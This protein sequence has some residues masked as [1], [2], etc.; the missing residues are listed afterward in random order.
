LADRTLVGVPDQQGTWS[1]ARLARETFALTFRGSRQ[2]LAEV[3]ARRTQVTLLFLA[4]ASRC[5]ILAQ[6][7]LDVA[8]ASGAT[9][10]LAWPWDWRPA[11]LLSRWRGHWSCCGPSA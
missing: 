3:S 1:P 6:A 8:A 5:V 9:R 4:L 10:A 2:D 11:A 7:G